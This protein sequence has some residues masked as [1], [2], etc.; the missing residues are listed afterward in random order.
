M[1]I[2]E[3]K[4]VLDKAFKVIETSNPTHRATTERYISL[5]NRRLHKLKDDDFWAIAGAS[6]ALKEAF[7]RKFGSFIPR[8]EAVEG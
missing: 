7:I 8:S 6:L 4:V 2:L 3:A 1:V 5:V